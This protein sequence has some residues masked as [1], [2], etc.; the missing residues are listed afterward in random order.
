M[1]Y[2]LIVFH[3]SVSSIHITFHINFASKSLIILI[4]TTFN[5]SFLLFS[6]SLSSYKRL[7]GKYCQIS[8]YLILVQNLYV[9]LDS[10]YIDFLRR[11]QTAAN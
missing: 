6:E 9:F 2:K 8:F 3:Y 7:G 4:S 5:R 11:I 1:I 10:I